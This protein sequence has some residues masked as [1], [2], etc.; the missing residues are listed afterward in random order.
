MISKTFRKTVVSTGLG[1][2]ILGLATLH[3]EKAMDGDEGHEGWEG[4]GRIEE[5]MKEHLK[6]ALELNDEQAKKVDELNKADHDNSKLLKDKVEAD[7]ANLKVLVDKK[8]G[9]E[10]L[11]TA[12]EGLKQDHKAMQEAHQKH[13]EAMQAILSPTQ[14]AKAVLM[15][16]EHMG[17]S[18]M[19]GHEGWG[20][21]EKGREKDKDGKK[22]DDD[23][24]KKD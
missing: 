7:L 8:A 3:A 4:Q 1:V 9:D 23:G 15:M 2:L 12:I 24:D 19:G 6:K 21:E 14:Q 18:M 17:H 5:G 13:M 22:P 10:E 16:R 11:K 20:H